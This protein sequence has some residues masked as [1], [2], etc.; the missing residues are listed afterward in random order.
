MDN[1][2]DL[3]A[4]AMETAAL[5]TG[6][7]AARGYELVVVGGS[8]VEF[9]TEGAYMSG[10][11]DMCRT[12]AAPI[13]LREQQEIMAA[14][15]ARG[16]P[17]TWR[18]GELFVDLLGQLENESLAPLRRLG[19]KRGE[20]LLAPPELLIVER[21]LSATY[22]RANAAEEACA[23]KLLAVCIGG[24]VAV[25]WDEVLRLARL[26]S[27]GVAEEVLRLKKEVAGVLD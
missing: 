14:L 8:A 5:V 3:L 4:M 7:F 16:G 2:R 13:P 19:T 15:D 18:V 26:P 10:D 12:N 24:S 21:T 9:Y 17:R 23:R 6:A 20:V 22:P 25:D 1:S 27:F 11:I